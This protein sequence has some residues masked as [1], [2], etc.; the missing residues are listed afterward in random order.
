D[1]VTSV[2]TD[3]GIIAAFIAGALALGSLTLSRRSA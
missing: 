2:L 3:L 1:P